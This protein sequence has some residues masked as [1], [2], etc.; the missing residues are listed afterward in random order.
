MSDAF[1]RFCGAAD[2]HALVTLCL[3]AC[4]AMHSRFLGALTDF[5]LDAPKPDL[6]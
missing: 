6:H 1:T 4:K 3:D 2:E 5:G